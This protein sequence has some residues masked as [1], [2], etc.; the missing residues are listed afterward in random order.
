MAACGL[1]ADCGT[2][3]PRNF[4]QIALQ[5]FFSRLDN[6]RRPRSP[7]C[8][9]SE[10]TLGTNL[11]GE[12]SAHRRNL[13]LTTHNAY[14]WQ[15]S[16]PPAGFE[17]PIPSTQAATDQRLRWRDNQDRH[18]SICIPVTATWVW[19]ADMNPLHTALANKEIKWKVSSIRPAILLFPVSMIYCQQSRVLLHN[20][21]RQC[22]YNV[23]LRGVRATVVV[24]GKQ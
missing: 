7:H 11:L 15:T 12:W 9:G 17:P 10:I 5:Y 24:V 3:P 1:S 21:D 20:K 8:W 19:R 22:T 13:Y 14:Q 18:L 16:M 2:R 4:S 23:T 6:S